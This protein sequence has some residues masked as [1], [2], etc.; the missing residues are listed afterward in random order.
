MTYITI[1]PDQE[2]ALE[3]STSKLADTLTFIKQDLLIKKKII[4]NATGFESYQ[5]E[6]NDDISFIESVEEKLR[7]L[8]FV[9]QDWAANRHDLLSEIVDDN[10]D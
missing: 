9:R 8:Y 2:E 1:T 4:S 3:E 10:N 5:D 6:L 7:A